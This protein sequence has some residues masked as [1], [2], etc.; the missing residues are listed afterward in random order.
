MLIAAASW[1]MP[2]ERRAR[3]YHEWMAELEEYDR[4]G[5]SLL[6]PALRIFGTAPATRRA[7]RPTGLGLVTAILRGFGDRLFIFLDA[8]ARWRGWHITRLHGATGRRYRDPRFDA[9]FKL[10]RHGKAAE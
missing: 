5:I 1:M 9:L 2:R 3:Y 10:T 6:H 7:M 4:E 8:E